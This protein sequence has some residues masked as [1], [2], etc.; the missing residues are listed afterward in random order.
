MKNVLSPPDFLISMRAYEYKWYICDRM[1]MCEQPK[2]AL[3][4]IEIKPIQT[5]LFE[6]GKKAIA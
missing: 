5:T 6:A 2:Q 4:G 1:S 3:K